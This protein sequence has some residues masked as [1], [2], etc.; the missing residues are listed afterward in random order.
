VRHPG[1]PSRKRGAASLAVVLVLFFILAMVAAY[2]NRNLIFEQRTS[3]NS[4]RSARA[5]AAA[6]A[7]IDW[8]IAMLNGGAINT[9]CAPGSAPAN[10]DFKTRYL[11]LQ[12]DGSFA[13]VTWSTTPG[14]FTG[15]PPQVQAQ[16]ACTALLGGGWNC[17]CPTAG[18]SAQLNSANR[19]SSVFVVGFDPGRQRPGV[20]AIRVRG[21]HNVRAGADGDVNTY[22]SCHV[23][24][25]TATEVAVK[26][27]QVDASAIVRVS[28]GLVSALPVAPAAA[29][30][31]ARDIKQ[32]TGVLNA[33]NPDPA[34]GVALRA[35]GAVD[36]APKVQVAGPAG[37]TSNLVTSDDLDLK[38]IPATDFFR[39][40]LGLPS[41]SYRQQPATVT[42]PVGCNL[43]TVTA[44]N[45]TR[46]IFFDGNLD[47]GTASP[48]GSTETPTM[49]VVTG[50]VVISSAIEFNGVIFAGRDLRWSAA[51]GKVNGAIIVGQDYIGSGTA[52]VTFDRDIVRR[53]HKSYGSFVRIP[54]SW[55]TEN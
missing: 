23:N 47:L 35:G 13:P 38:I 26:A 21:C 43:S 10:N 15:G 2:T 39:T 55:N 24:D 20:A 27:V 1:R 50:D 36:G 37:S 11:T 12:P 34:T 40:A 45:P 8:T 7:G 49:L 16:P 48:I 33:V 32:D 4:Y 17:S 22:G 30:T 52:N 18:P 42:C 14:V 5:L 51:G 46:V 9:Q 29:V 19:E 6:D 44:E 28:L 41:D 31:A 54:G 3:A 53:V 25:M